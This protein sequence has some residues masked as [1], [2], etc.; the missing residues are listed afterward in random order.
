MYVSCVAL[1]KYLSFHPK[2]YNFTGEWSKSKDLEEGRPESPG[3]D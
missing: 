1:K 3:P 2:N